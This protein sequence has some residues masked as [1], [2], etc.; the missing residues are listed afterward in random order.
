MALNS[1]GEY[2]FDSKIL[3]RL[4]GA[5]K[6][7]RRRS[8]AALKRSGFRPCGTGA[9]S[10]TGA[11]L[12][13]LDMGITNLLSEAMNHSESGIEHLII[14]VHPNRNDGKDASG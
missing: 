14:I 7:Q 4:H 13:E 2:R 10:V 6:N 5:S 1:N 11:S 12:R 8:A 9:Y 3:L